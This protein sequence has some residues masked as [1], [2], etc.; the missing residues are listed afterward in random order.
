MSPELHLLDHLVEAVGVFGI[1][2]GFGDDFQ[3]SLELE[4]LDRFGDALTADAD[5][6][7][8]LDP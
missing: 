7:H 6:T 2:A 3:P 4:H 5:R 1:G 8:H